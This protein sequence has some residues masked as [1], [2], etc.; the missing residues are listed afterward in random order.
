[1]LNIKKFRI[2]K[3]KKVSSILKLE[4]ISLK[5][6]KKTILDNLNL[7]LNHGQI[8][9][10]LGPNGVGKSTIFNLITGLISPD[11]GT[12]TINNEIVNKLPIYKRAL[13]F[14][15]GFVPQYGGYFHDLTIDENL[16]AIAE[17]TINNENIRNEKV[18]SLI[19]QFELD[20]VRFSKA[21]LLS[22]GQKKKISY[23][24]CTYF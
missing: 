18:N 15:I 5:F 19:S 22:G 14:K 12:I 8:L 3:F 13:K 6:G 24:N 7:E 1:M 9:G 4:K 11:Y 16:K 10:L 20:N 21:N 17:I 23:S 2:K